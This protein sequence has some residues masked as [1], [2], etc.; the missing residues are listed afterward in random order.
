M[1]LLH[2]L[3]DTH[4]HTQIFILNVGIWSR[5]DFCNSHFVLNIC[6]PVDKL[7][8]KGKDVQ[9]SG[10]LQSYPDQF[11]GFVFKKVS[12]QHEQI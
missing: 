8:K 5:S 6:D 7:Y 12:Y 2:N 4:T 11:L 9:S 1:Y 3:L 10:A